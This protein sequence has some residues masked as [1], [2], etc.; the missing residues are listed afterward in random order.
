LAAQLLALDL[1]AIDR[2]A[3]MMAANDIESVAV[4][5]IHSYANPKHERAAAARLH[6]LLPSLYVSLSSSVCPNRE[7]ERFTTTAANAYIQP[8]IAG[9]SI[10]RQAPVEI[11][12]RAPLLLMT[13]AGGLTTLQMPV[14]S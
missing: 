4:C 5:F 10:A 11:G 6:E 1:E 12:V 7:Y 2:H 9:I 14:S 13:S 3:E 8:V